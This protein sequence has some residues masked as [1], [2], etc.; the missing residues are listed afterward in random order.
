M[1]SRFLTGRA[2]L[3]LLATMLSLPVGVC[4]AADLGGR[5]VD[6]RS[7]LPL[8]GASVALLPG[9]RALRCCTRGYF[10]F[11][12][13]EP[14]TYNILVSSRGYREQLVPVQVEAEGRWVEVG[15]SHS[16]VEKV[17]V[18]AELP[19]LLATT[20]LEDQDLTTLVVPD[21]GRL[22]R[23]V[24]GVHAARRG[25]LGLDPVVRGLREEQIATYVDG[26]RSFSACPGRME[27]GAGH[28]DPA[29]VSRIEIVKGPQALTVGPGALSAITVETA[30][31][32]SF[33]DRS[34][35]GK[36]RLGAESNTEARSGHLNLSG[37]RAGAGYLL[38]LTTRAGNDYRAGDGSLVPGDYQ[39]DE[40]RFA[41]E[42]SLSD[43][44]SLAADLGYLDVGEVDYPGRT[45][46][47]RATDIRS[48][49]MSLNHTAGLGTFL[50]YRASLNGSNVD[51]VMDNFDKP[52][53]AMMEAKADTGTETYS[54]NIGFDWSRPEKWFLTAGID[55]YDLTQNG[56]RVV[57]RTADGALLYDD[58]IWAD[59]RI[60]HVGLFAKQD[61]RTAGEQEWS[62]AIRFDGVSADSAPPS[63]FFLDN[64]TGDLAQDE[65]NVGVSLAWKKLF[66]ER[67]T[68]MSG[69]GRAVRTAS[70]LERYS[71]RYPSTRF[72]VTAEFL[73]DPDIDP[74][75][76]YQLDLDL[77]RTGPRV[78]LRCDAFYRVID[79]YITIVPDAT[80]T[81]LLPASL[82]TVYRYVNG[83][84]A[85][86]AGFEVV[87]TIGLGAAWQLQLQ[88][89]YV[90]AEDRQIDE[91]V[92]GIPPLRGSAALRYT[93]PSQRC[94]VEGSVTAV[95]R[96]DRVAVSRLE[97]ETAGY[98]LYGL[99]AGVRLAEGAT[100]EVVGQNLSDRPYVDHLNSID[101]TAGARVA[102][103]GRTVSLGLLWEF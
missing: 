57:R 89:D 12:T 11:E 24:P 103:P 49:G 4:R 42:W 7:G 23:E 44:T 54:A 62:W 22:L 58:P 15:L 18:R 95:D 39:S 47:A 25:A 56:V 26:G 101:P 64:T 38:A 41:G 36:L 28:A 35:T 82:D 59:A 85:V 60:T 67:W 43:R 83:G 32:G 74:E 84:Q 30:R 90:R 80:L 99:R 48:Y 92:F 45:M 68:V 87:A 29:V 9:E 50:G 51:H 27:S 98:T 6:A 100:L 97:V 78:D 33:D 8:A 10:S 86:F 88:A 96:Q 31:P 61:V 75:I 13:I 3:A 21:V 1:I 69:L 40:A 37:G 71:N 65:F 52:Q 5:V 46:D 81:K 73:G 34:F 63:Q 102:E 93:Y 66:G 72:Q 19:D 20:R 16:L 77:H 2:S 17:E 55:G 70:T 94:Y 76:A 91:P 53:A 14:G 79:D